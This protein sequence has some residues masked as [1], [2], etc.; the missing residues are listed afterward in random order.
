MDKPGAWARRLTI[1]VPAERIATERR[2]AIQR[3]SKQ[4]RL[5]GFR[6]GKVPATV[7]EKRFGQAIEQETLEK[8]I[9]SAYREALDRE[10][11]QPITQGSIENV[12]Y[13]TG[14]D[15]RFDVAF[16][17]RPEIELD[18]LGGFAVMRE[19][20]TIDDAQVDQVLQRLREE[21][22]TFT[23]RETGTPVVGD[24]VVVEITPLDEAFAE[25]APPAQPRR[26]DITIG[27]GHALPPIEDAIRTLTPGGEAEFTVDLPENSED[28]AS[29]SKPHRLHIRLAEVKEPTYPALDD[30]FAK[31]VGAFESLDDLRGRVKEDLETEAGRDAE[32]RV[33]MTLL[34][35]VIEANPFDVPRSMVQQYLEAMVPTREGMDP[36]RVAAVREQAYPEAEEALRRMLVIE[37]IAEMESLSATGDEV[38]AKVEELASRINRP[39]P[40]V[41]T[42][43]RKG[44][45]LSE[46][47]REIT[48]EK[49]F[50]Y[51]KS[52]STIE[53]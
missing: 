11:L 36:E 43:L 28:P 34:S 51:L 27:E 26:Y 4:A 7:M 41:R 48:E 35:Q 14:T 29:G 37:R 17:V 22:A 9:S 6:K 45:R 33:R 32:R 39:V 23:A 46:I 38:E 44:N 53:G 16:E 31:S 40:E 1:T 8:V 25:A 18:R 49:V 10:Q 47:E 20:A 50:D 42:Q 24:Q 2:D 13:E 3:L 15:L 12:E 19:T 5:P 21:Q 52:L 30:E